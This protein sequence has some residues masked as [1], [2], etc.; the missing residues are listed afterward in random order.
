M[1]SWYIWKYL[2]LYTNTVLDG[3]VRLW[4]CPFAIETT[5]LLSDFKTKQIFGIL[6]ERVTFLKPL[7]ALQAPAER[8]A[9]GAP[10][11]FSIATE[12]GVS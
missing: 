5:F 1:N 9:E 4:F 10:N 7:G 2:Y 12:G 11:F 3:T 6:M 8:G